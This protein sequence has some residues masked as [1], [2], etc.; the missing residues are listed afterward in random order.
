MNKRF[1]L[2]KLTLTDFKPAAF[3][4]AT[5]KLQLDQNKGKEPIATPGADPVPEGRTTLRLNKLR[6][7]VSSQ[8]SEVT[9]LSEPEP[10]QAS[11]VQ[12]DVP[13]VATIPVVIQVQSASSVQPPV[14]QVP[15]PL[16]VKPTALSLPPSVTYVVEPSSEKNLSPAAEQT[17]L[18]TDP[19]SSQ[20]RAAALHVKSVRRRNS[21]HQQDLDPDDS[22][23]FNTRQPK[24]LKDSFFKACRDKGATPSI[25]LR[26]LMKSYCG[27]CLILVFCGFHIFAATTKDSVYTTDQL[28]SYFYGKSFGLPSVIPDLKSSVA[29]RHS[30]WQS[31]SQDST[32]YVYADHSNTRLE[33]KVEIPILDLKYLKDRSKDKIEFRA[34]FMKSLS[35]ILAAQKNVDGLASRAGTVRVRLDYLKT[36]MSLKLANKSE[37]FPIEDE[38]YAIQAQQNEAQS[39]LEQRI[40][41]LAV[42]AGNEW[43][44]AYHMILKWD[45]RLF[46]D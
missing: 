42:V 10:A 23:A 32:D 46:N 15:V 24:W 37:I 27:L 12:P 4:E 17:I 21:Q 38:L 31:G 28:L 30:L 25:V 1:D 14:S 26:N 16:D 43:Y 40:I 5:T 11:L 3:R 18:V 22:V 36:Q 29:V 41:D 20:V 19:S 44:E 35:K 8:S 33:A 9:K 34:F 2:Q 39:V 6:G 7:V 45:G 13:S